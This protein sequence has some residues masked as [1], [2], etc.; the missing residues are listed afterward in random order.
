MI[1]SDGSI[2]TCEQDVL[3]KHAL[4]RVGND[5]IRDIWLNRFGALRAQHAAGNWTNAPLCRNCREWHRP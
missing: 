5:C 4:G 1:L 3:G 2:V